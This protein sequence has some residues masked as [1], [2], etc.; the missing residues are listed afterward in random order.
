M[1]KGMPIVDFEHDSICRDCA[2]G[3][4]V[5]NNFPSIS[6]ISKGILELIHLYVCGPMSS[7]SLN[8]YLY[9]VLFIDEF[10]RNSWIY[11]L[12]DKSENIYEFKEFKALV[13]NYT[14]TQICPLRSNNGGDF[15]SHAFNDICC[16]AII[17]T[18]LKVAY[19]P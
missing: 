10:S 19:N 5:K 7:P 16:D 11:F 13:E 9:Y 2:L 18:Q 15:A 6:S 3:N 12:K 4:N 8:G 14:G 1:V 17:C